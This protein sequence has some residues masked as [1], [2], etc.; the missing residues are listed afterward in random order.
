MSGEVKFS[1]AMKINSQYNQKSGYEISR[2]S[3]RSGY[4]GKQTNE[5]T[6]CFFHSAYNHDQY[7]KTWDLTG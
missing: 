5:Q 1:L 3:A 4:R 2:H 6:N 7:I